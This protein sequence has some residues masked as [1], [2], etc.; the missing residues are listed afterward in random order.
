MC[1]N[2][3][4]V[5]HDHHGHHRVNH[6]CCKSRTTVKCGCH[7]HGHYTTHEYH[8]E[9]H[10]GSETPKAGT[11][12]IA[13]IRAHLSKLVDEISSLQA[14]LKALSDKEKCENPEKLEG[15]PGDCAPEQ[16]EEC[17]GDEKDHSCDD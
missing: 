4:S 14:Q 8:C 3:K 2:R 5:C 17:H 6:C 11:G 13:D 9:C 1:G 7:H 10:T 15:E 16:I 12:E